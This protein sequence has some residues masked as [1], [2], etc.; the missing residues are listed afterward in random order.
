MEIAFDRSEW[1]LIKAMIQKIGLGDTVLARVEAGCR[2]LQA[3]IRV[4]DLNFDP[5][6][7][8]RTVQQGFLLSP[9]LFDTC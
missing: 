3:I 1:G 2:K 6:A 4:N 7:L 9:L 8:T 5:I